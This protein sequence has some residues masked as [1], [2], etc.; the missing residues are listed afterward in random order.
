MFLL[1]FLTTL[2]REEYSKRFEFY[3][4]SNRYTGFV[5]NKDWFYIRAMLSDLIV[6]SGNEKWPDKNNGIKHII[7]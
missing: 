7:T 2:D 5:A 1:C 3:K 6:P 4:T